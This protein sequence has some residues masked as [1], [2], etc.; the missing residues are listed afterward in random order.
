MVESIVNE[1]QN[2]ADKYD[3]SIEK[4]RGVFEDERRETIE[5]WSNYAAE[6]YMIFIKEPEFPWYTL[7]LSNGE[8]AMMQNLRVLMI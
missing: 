6:N 5:E 2:I 4:Q 1:L 7:S 8:G 3:M